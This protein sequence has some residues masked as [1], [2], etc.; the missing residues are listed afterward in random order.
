MSRAEENLKAAFARNKK[1]SHMHDTFG[2]FVRY[3]NSNVE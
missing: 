1:F 3:S 2:M